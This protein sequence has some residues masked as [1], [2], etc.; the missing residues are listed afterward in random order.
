MQQMSGDWVSVTDSTFL[1]ELFLQ[2]LVLESTSTMATLEG[3]AEFSNNVVEVAAPTIAATLNS[4]LK[5]KNS[6][7]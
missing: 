2:R 7:S 1:R 3:I 4:S 5:S 6:P